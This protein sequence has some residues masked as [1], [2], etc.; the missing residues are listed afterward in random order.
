MSEFDY[1]Q[2]NNTSI[3]LIKK[4]IIDHFDHDYISSIHILVPQI[5]VTLR[6]VL[7]SKGIIPLKIEK[8]GKEA[9]IYENELGGLLVDV[10]GINLRNKV[11]HGL[12]DSI[13]EFNHPISYSLI[14]VLLMLIR[15][16]L[17]QP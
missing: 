9:R 7:S 2:K 17:E 13:E 1:Y 8:E 6:A 15:S 12:M 3:H 10:T 4:A 16:S 11:S 14:H 5:E